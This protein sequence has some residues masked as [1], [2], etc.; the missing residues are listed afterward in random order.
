MKTLE[1]NQM[2]KF[3]GGMEENQGG[4]DWVNCVLFIPALISPFGRRHIRYMVWLSV[5]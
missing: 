1:L 4:M 3:Q 5:Y 2:E